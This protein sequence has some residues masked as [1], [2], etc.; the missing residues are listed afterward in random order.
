MLVGLA[1]LAGAA[2]VASDQH[3]VAG[4][5]AVV[6]AFAAVPTWIGLPL[7]AVM[8]LGTLW[9]G[10][11]LT[12]ILLVRQSRL[13]WQPGAALFVS[14]ALAFR[15]DN[16]I[17]AVIERPRPSAVIEGIEVREHIDGF[18]FP[19]GHTTMAAAIAGALHPVLSPRARLAAWGAVAV[20]AIAR[21]HVAAHWP[22]DLVGGLAL[23]VTLASLAWLAVTLVSDATRSPRPA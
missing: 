3:Y 5:V 1:V 18:A 10:L 11:T 23:G 8:Q 7:R 9:V 19:S 15:T 17:K 2:V 4:E 13:G 21:M 20:T 22:L 14:V 6:E 16:V 12:G